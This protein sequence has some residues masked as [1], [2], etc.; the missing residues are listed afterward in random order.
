MADS[1]EKQANSP[2]FL[3]P[4]HNPPFFFIIR[5]HLN[6]YTVTGKNTDMVNP[7][8]AGEMAENRAALVEFYPKGS[9]RK[10]L[11]YYTLFLDWIITHTGCDKEKH[12]PL[13]VFSQGGTDC[14]EASK[15][16]LINCIGLHW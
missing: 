15:P 16:A 9:G 12:S 8:F 11:D 6:Y 4:A 3:E 5:R 1:S 7:H 13:S 10:R 2:A 14:G